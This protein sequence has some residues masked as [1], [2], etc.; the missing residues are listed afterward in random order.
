MSLEPERG[1]HAAS[2]LPGLRTSKRQESSDPNNSF[3]RSLHFGTRWQS[4]ARHRFR[5]HHAALKRP[6]FSCAQKRRRRGALPAQ[7]KTIAEFARFRGSLHDFETGYRGHKRFNILDCG[8]KR[9][10]TPLLS[11]RR[12]FKTSTFLVRS[13]ASST[14]AFCRRSPR[15]RP[16]GETARAGELAVNPES[17]IQN[18]KSW[19]HG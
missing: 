4:G 6:R 19:S 10:A 3:R 7:S 14:L 18:P 2:T 8:G 9:S 11:A 1:I 12:A 16:K 15:G 5:P 13:K 17:K